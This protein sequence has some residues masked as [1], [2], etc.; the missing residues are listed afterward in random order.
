MHQRARVAA[1][2]QPIPAQRQARPSDQSPK[3]ML[4][5]VWRPT[6]GRTRLLMTVCR[7]VITAGALLLAGLAP[8]GH[9][10]AAPVPIEAFARF[11]AVTGVTISGDGKHIAGI[12]AAQGQKRPTYRKSRSGFRRTPIASSM[13]ASSATTKSSSSSNN[14]SCNRMVGPLSRVSSIWPTWT[15]AISSSPSR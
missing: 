12:V 3:P 6:P 14:R 5:F 7:S 10:T 4:T 11:E 2:K 1:P 9:A 15:A 13:S 8:G